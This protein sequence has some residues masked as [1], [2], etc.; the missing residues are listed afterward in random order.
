MVPPYIGGAQ[1]EGSLGEFSRTLDVVSVVGRTPGGAVNVHLVLAVQSRHGFH[2]VGDSTVQHPNPFS[3]QPVSELSEFFLRRS[4]ACSKPYWL[5]QHKG[6]FDSVFF[7]FAGRM[8]IF[9]PPCPFLWI[10]GS[11]STKRCVRF[12]NSSD[13]RKLQCITMTTVKIN[14]E[15]QSSFPR[16]VHSTGQR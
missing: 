11:R 9:C 5:K 8:K 4:S 13:Q 6:S 1:V 3:V 2:C 10:A 12:N 15:L 16:H 7:Q 14:A